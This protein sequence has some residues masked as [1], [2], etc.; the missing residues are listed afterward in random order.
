MWGIEP[1]EAAA[2]LAQQR[3]DK[4]L[5]GTF[6][7]AFNDIPDHYFDLVVCNDVIEHLPDPDEFLESIKLKLRT[8]AYIIGSVPDVRYAWNLYDLL[9]KKDWKYTDSGILDRTHLKFFTEISLRRLLKIH[10]FDIEKFHGIN[11]V[12]VSAKSPK[13]LFFSFVFAMLIF[14]SF[15]FYQDIRFLQFAFRAK[16]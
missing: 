7:T 15:G 8:N 12:F 4:V 2:R 1:V 13:E 11:S 6:E 16:L 9:V 5:I 10:N 3:M 14:L